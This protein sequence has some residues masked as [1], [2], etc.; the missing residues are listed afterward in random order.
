M[1]VIGFAA[2]LRR[3]THDCVAATSTPFIDSW[4]R[5][6]VIERSRYGCLKNLLEEFGIRRA[7]HDLVEPMVCFRN[8]LKG[9]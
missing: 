6:C 3:L 9:S 4:L 5:A 8:N 7:G 2:A 1:A